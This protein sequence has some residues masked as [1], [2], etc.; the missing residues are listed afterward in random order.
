[1]KVFITNNTKIFL[2][3][4]W[5]RS[6]NYFS[7]AISPVALPNLSIHIARIIN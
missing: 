7:V 1:M 6:N 5:L 3:E 4:S 2:P